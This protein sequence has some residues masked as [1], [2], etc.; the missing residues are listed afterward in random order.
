MNYFIE[1]SDETGPLFPQSIGLITW[2]MT[3]AI[4]I[5]IHHANN[6]LPVIEKW[7]FAADSQKEF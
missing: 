5:P 1:F 7:S 4:H 3:Y 2:L 6:F